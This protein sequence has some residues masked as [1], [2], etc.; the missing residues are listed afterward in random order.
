LCGIR[1]SSTVAGVVRPMAW[2]S[3]QSG[4]SRKNAARAF[5]H[6]RVYP[7][8]RELG[9]FLSALRLRSVCL[10]I[11]SRSWSEN[12][13][14]AY[15][16]IHRCTHQNIHTSKNAQQKNRS[17]LPPAAVKFRTQFA[18]T[19]NHHNQLERSV[20]RN[21]RISSPKSLRRSLRAGTILKRAERKTVTF[22]P[23]LNGSDSHTARRRSDFLRR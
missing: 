18:L 22:S 15:S 13:A 10:V 11:L 7:R 2:H 20:K 5:S 19:Q 4:C 12:Y 6:R 21:L 1:W 23:S 3:T 17:G 8:C 9:R 14:A 16:C